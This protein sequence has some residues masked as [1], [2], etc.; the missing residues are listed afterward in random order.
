MHLENDRKI[1]LVVDIGNTNITCGVY[2]N[3]TLVG[4]FRFYSTTN[5]TADEYYS[6]LSDLIRD[7][8]SGIEAITFSSVVPELSRIWQHLFRKFIDAPVLE[9]N[10]ASQLGLTYKVDDASIIGSDLVVN[11]YGAWCK[12]KTNCIII[13]LGTATTIQFVTAEGSFEGVTIAPGMRSGA[14]HLLDKAAL[15]SQIEIST[16]ETL[17]G[18]NTKDALLSGIVNGHALMIEAFVQKI[19]LHYFERKEVKTILT[20]GI[21]DLLMPLM[22]SVDYVDK[23]LTLDG[24]YLAGKKLQVK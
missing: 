9:I 21:A 7:Y 6:L 3:D 18:T 8:A 23:T 12:Y 4:L 1:S 22:K 24:I 5:R 16:P 20:G 13:D 19:K 2:K 14:A 11:A 17:L 10:A 15:L